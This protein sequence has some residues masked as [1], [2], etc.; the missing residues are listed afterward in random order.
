M[1]AS[2]Q[3]PQAEN[4]AARPIEI[5]APVGGPAGLEAAVWAGAD[6]VY[7]GLKG[8]NA[9]RGADNFTPQELREAV[10]LCHA[11][12]VGVH[13]T[14][15]TLAHA[16]ELPGLLQALESICEAGA[17]A[18][19]VQ[20]WAAARLVRQHAPGLRLHASTQLAVCDLAGA[21][22]AAQYGFS[23]VVL[24]RELSAEEIALITRECGIETEVFVHGAQCMSVSGQCYLS[25]FLGG[26]S[27]NRGGCAQPC[28]LPCTAFTGARPPAGGPVCH[29]LSLKDLSLLARLPELAAMGVASVKIEGRLRPPEYVA[30]AV[31]AARLARNGQPYDAR[32]LEQVF[33]RSGFTDGY[34]TARRGGGMFG[35]RRAEDLAV[36]RAAEPAIRELYRRP[37]ARVPVSMALTL[38]AEGARLTVSDG[39]QRATAYA[40]AAADTQPPGPGYPQ[41]LR[42][43]LCKT[44]GTPF[45]AAESAVTL[46]GE[47][48]FYLPL[49]DIN[50]L[51][52]TALEQ[53]YQKR[54]D[55]PGPHFLPQAADVPEC[56]LPRGLARYTAA[57]AAAD[58]AALAEGRRRLAA[59]L[60][61]PRQLPE[62]LEKAFFRL[63]LPL[64]CAADIPADWRGRTVLELPRGNFGGTHAL[65]QAL[66]QAAAL[67]FTRF[68][69]NNP[70]HLFLVRQLA[71][72]TDAALELWGGFALNVLNPEA[73]RVLAGLG[74]HTQ[75]LSCELRVNELPA[76][77]NIG[78]RTALLAYGR[79]P[80]M[81]TRACP[82]QNVTD[83]ADCPRRGR[84]LDRKGEQLPIVC[85][86][87]VREIYNPIPLWLGDRQPEAACDLLTLY[88]TWEA[89]GRVQAVTQSFLAGSAFDGRF[90]RGLYYARRDGAE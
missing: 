66:Q 21:K 55:A 43:S 85:R 77:E 23:R 54:A 41:A 15:N 58:R 36:S 17:D 76:F 69:A 49:S 56:P 39:A 44:G 50:A 6:C 86:G 81:L 4:S 32:L 65:E 83:C 28:R 73:A 26:R 70:G 45:S 20:D 19:L 59:R 74:V 38:E 89:P 84:L 29:H 31:H 14:L 3:Q 52:R 78:V 67:G 68:E 90:T 57:E 12:G 11:Y 16:D 63:I 46:A 79:L 24:A 72:R 27:G 34:Y 37:L 9:R 25:A 13:V 47:R 71:E 51:R 33:S 62:G 22:L 7:L 1:S 64:R 88:F 61:S 2:A 30:A 60:E 40:S 48:Q 5:L 53:L 35:V 82:L 87:G 10:R 18:V 80:V 8:F 75:T 42:R